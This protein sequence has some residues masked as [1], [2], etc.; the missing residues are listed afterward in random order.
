MPYKDPTAQRLADRERQRRYRAR[1]R[2]KKRSAAVLA[3]PVPSDPVG[4]LVTW[5]REVLK[6]PP[7]HPAA[8]EPMVLPGFAVDFLRAGGTHTRAPCASPGR[9]PRVQSSRYWCSGTWA[10]PLRRPGW[11][12]AVASVSKEK[13]AELRTQVEGIAVASGLEGLR[14]KRSPYP[15]NVTSDSGSVEILSSDRTAGHSSSFDVVIVDET[16]LMPERSRDLLAGLRSS[17]SAKNGRIIHISV[18]GDSPLY[19]EILTNPATVAHIHAAPDGCELDDEE[20]W[21]AANPGLGTI[22]QTSY[23]RSE[24]ERIRGAPGDENSFRAYDLNQAL[25][26]T[27]EMILSPDDLRACF[28]DEL[29]PREGKCYLGFDFGE[30][31]SATTCTAIFPQTGRA[32]FWMA[33]GDVPPIAERAKRDDAPYA[34]MVQRGELHLYPGRV[35]RLD[36]FLSA[37]Q[38]DLA[39]VRVKAAAADS[40]KRQRSQGPS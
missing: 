12:G 15:G 3:F 22:K 6:V 19:G 30:A 39:G 36:A 13:A 9:T 5:S 35:V 38:H 28:A 33:F 29:P 7:G 11:R 16:G 4:E 17:V 26:P 31:V 18:R 2:E 37:V 25:D 32:E 27:R 23:M 24:V 40:Y 14:F 10:G 8:G 34:E 20:A 1:Q 21:K